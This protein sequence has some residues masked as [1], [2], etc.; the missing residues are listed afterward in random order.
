VETIAGRWTAALALAERAEEAAAANRETPCQFDRRSLLM[1]ALAAAKLGEEDEAQRL[2]DLAVRAG[3]VLGARWSDSALLRL[4]L[5]REDRAELERALELEPIPGPFDPDF[6]AARIDAL[7]ALGRRAEVEEVAPP[8]AARGGYAA[9]FAER[10]L[11]VVRGER[12]RLE[13]AMGRFE[14]MGL[15]WRAEETRTL[16]L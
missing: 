9:P 4:R 11:A 7:L 5:F 16:S 14:A 13:A 1:C 8:L 2:E 3:S 15:G 10:A 6:P 12:G